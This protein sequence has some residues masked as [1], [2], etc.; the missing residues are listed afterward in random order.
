MEQFFDNNIWNFWWGIGAFVLFV[1]L[2]FRLAFK[3]ILAAVDA[4]ERQIAGQMKEAEDAY[5]RAKRVQAEVDAKFA[6][7][8]SSIAAL[9]AD[10]R[11]H[12]EELKTDLLEKGR[13]E[14][15]AQR[16]RSLRDIDAA[17]NAALN[18][19]RGQIAEVA[20]QVAERII[21]EK[22]SPA[23]HETLVAETMAAYAAAGRESR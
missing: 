15:E 13:A 2:F 9:I 4:R 7:A 6:A 8:E 10:A 19:M 1:L 20:I 23:V 16:Q 3:H 17:R 12:A 5:L 11:K 18:S 14:I 21:R 22:M